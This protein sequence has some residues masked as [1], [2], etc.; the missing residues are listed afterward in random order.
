MDRNRVSGL[1]PSRQS[2]ARKSALDH[3]QT[4]APR[5]VRPEHQIRGFDRLLDDRDLT[6]IDLEIDQLR[7][8]AVLAGQLFLYLPLELRLRHLSGFVQPGCTFEALTLFVGDILE[9]PLTTTQD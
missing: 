1:L 7:R 5:L 3:L 6:L 9:A 2:P 8:L 4:V